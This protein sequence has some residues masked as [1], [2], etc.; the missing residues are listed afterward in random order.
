M[1]VRVVVRVGV[2]VVV[3]RAVV[4]ARLARLALPRLGERVGHR[5]PA[6]LAA[7]HLLFGEEARLERGGRRRV[8]ELLA[9][10]DELRLAVASTA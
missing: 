7:R 9:D 3:P 5:R 8:V 2:V 10:A 4:D 1:R 6:R